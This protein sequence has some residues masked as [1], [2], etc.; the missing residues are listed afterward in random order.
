M[1]SVGNG[2]SGRTLI[3]TGVTSSPTFA[4]I[5]TLS[6]LTQFAVVLAGGSGP[7]TVSNIGASGTVL[8]SNGPGSP[9]TYKSLPAS[10][11]STLT[12]NSG[13]AI[14]PS[15]G[16]INVLGTGSTTVVGSGSTLTLQMTGL[17]NHAVLVGAGTATI[18]NVGP[19]A[20]AGQILQSGGAS[21]D[22]SFSIATYPSTAGT[23]TNVLTSDGTNWVS[24]TAPGGGMLMAN[25]TL[26]N[27]QIKALLGTPI[28]LIAAPG[29]G[30]TIVVVNT[31]GKLNYGGTNAFTDPGAVGIGLTYGT[32]ASNSIQPSLLATSGVTATVNEVTLGPAVTLTA[33]YTL[34]NNAAVFANV[35]GGQNIA[36]NAAN[37]NTVSWQIQY[38]IATL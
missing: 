8:T 22:P 36:G 14:S 25:G 26:T 10:G 19:S 17:T 4:A 5:G 20:T 34:G 30:K 6:G 31:I 37:N 9:P 3:G 13:G 12:G 33:P 21:A 23:A 32:T 11:V 1:A 15:S 24:S 18:T 16:N 7:F 35:L 27:A 38:Y 29:S 2:Q 28:Q